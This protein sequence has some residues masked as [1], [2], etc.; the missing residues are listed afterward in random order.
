MIPVLLACVVSWYLLKAVGRRVP[1][2]G[3]LVDR[4]VPWTGKLHAW[5]L[6]APATFCYIAVF[7]CF[8]LVQTTSPPRL[9]DVLTRVNSTSLFE[10][11][12]DALDVLAT[13]AFWVADRG[14]GLALYAVAFATAVAWAERRYGTPRLILIALSGHVLGSLI[15][16]GLLQNQI[17]SGR[18]SEKLIYSTDVGV[19]Y[20]LVAS[21]AAAVLV[22]RGRVRLVAAVCVLAVLVTPM[23][24]DRTIWDL[25]HVIAAACGLAVAALSLLA[26]PLR[27]PPPLRV[28][29]V[30][31]VPREGGVQDVQEGQDRA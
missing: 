23:I 25:G 9:V 15:T 22:M 6:S 21:V 26:G 12:R 28:P 27:E 14:S 29:R 30:Q 7:T 31:R 11:R 4:V 20:M 8:T 13:S 17:N 3:R 2:V 16:E 18:A 10:L 19:S 1:P 5:V 24:S